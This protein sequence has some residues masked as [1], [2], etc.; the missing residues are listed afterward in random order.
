MVSGDGFY[1]R[2]AD[3]SL[4]LH[5]DGRFH[6][7][8][9][10]ANEMFSNS[11]AGRGGG[12]GGL[13]LDPL[14][15][16]HDAA[17]PIISKILAVPDLRAKYIGFIRDV[18]DK[19]LDWKTLGLVVKQYRDLIA[20]DVAR[21]TRKLYSTDEFLRGTADD[22]TLRSFIDQRRTFLLNWVAQQSAPP[23]AQ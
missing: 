16:Q 9:H 10:D 12:G 6:F 5:P 20:D 3:Y 14:A 22:G 15:A 17:K 21:D 7:V 2:A 23:A 4:Y 18:A 8:F 11:G 13:T 1:A 19:G